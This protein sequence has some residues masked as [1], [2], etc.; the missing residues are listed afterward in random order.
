MNGGISP[1]AI[2]AFDC[3]NILL[4][5]LDR[6]MKKNNYSYYDLIESRKV[7]S[8]LNTNS[9]SGIGLNLFNCHKIS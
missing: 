4:Y 5:G 2:G 8:V 1:D 7:S 9:F 6:F 3:T